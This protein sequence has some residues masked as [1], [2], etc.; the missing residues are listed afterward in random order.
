M[1]KENSNELKVNTKAIKTRDSDFP[2][3]GYISK[4]IKLFQMCDYCVVWRIF[5]FNNLKVVDQ[6]NYRAE[7]SWYEFTEAGM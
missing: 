1:V 5:Q 6:T 3:N 4:E 2:N 7:V